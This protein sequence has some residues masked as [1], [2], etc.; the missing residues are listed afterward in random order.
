MVIDGKL[1]EGPHGLAGEIGH[2]PLPFREATD[3]PVVACGCGQKGCLD[4]SIG[5]PALV[6]LYQEMTGKEAGAA[7]IA[8]RARKGGTEALRVLDRFYTVIAK[9]MVTVIHVYDPEIIVVSGGL[10]ELPGL[11]REVPARWGAYALCK[12]LKTG[13]VPAMHGLMSGMRG[14]AR[15]GN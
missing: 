9:A 2:L 15:I 1:V 11:Y 10:S 7:L 14:A 12:N 8:E 13:F 3:G 5:G 6:R 4:K